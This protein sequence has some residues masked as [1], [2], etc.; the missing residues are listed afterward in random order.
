METLVKVLMDERS[1]WA[2]LRDELH[3]MLTTMF[4]FT[5]NASVIRECK[6]PSEGERLFFIV[7]L[8]VLVP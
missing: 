5:T 2:K 6:P 7:I 4:M 1:E 8:A 3:V